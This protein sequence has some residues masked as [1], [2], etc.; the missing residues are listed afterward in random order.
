MQK[1]ISI[2]VLYIISGLQLGGCEKHL[3][4]LLPELIRMGVVPVVFSLN[5]RGPLSEQLEQSGVQILYPSYSN[6]LHSFPKILKWLLTGFFSAFALIKYMLVHKPKIV[7]MFLPTAYIFGGFCSIISRVSVKIMSRRS[8]N[9]YQNKYPL[10]LPIEKFL[11]KRMDFLIGNSKSV[12]NDLVQEAQDAKKILTIYNGVQIKRPITKGVKSGVRNELG[13]SGEVIVFAITANLIPYKG[14]DFLLESLSMIKGSL[15]DNWLLLVIGEDRGNLPKLKSKAKSLGLDENIRWLGLQKDV[16]YFLSAADIGI[17][18]SH[19]EGFAN[20]VLEYMEAS[21][22]SIV[23]MGGNAEAVVNGVTG[24]VISPGE[25]GEL[26][27]AILNL[28]E[29]ARRRKDMG[30]DARKRVSSSFSHKE[31]AINY[32]LCYHKAINFKQGQTDVT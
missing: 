23:T 22:P 19:E 18:C 7:H 12:S 26:A 17:L 1:K 27:S 13:I 14:H 3:V 4:Q 21:L 5:G 9:H 31:C 32:I 29:N 24:L 2:N 11:H 20:A 30:K 15:K 25:R 8:R 6:L 16:R 28:K 10:I